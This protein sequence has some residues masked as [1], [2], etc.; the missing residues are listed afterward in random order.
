M[1]KKNNFFSRKPF[2]LLAA[3]AVLLAGST[4]G[5]TR[6]ALTYYS[7]NYSAE[8][9]VPSI[10]VSLLE[11]GSVVAKRDY[12]HK[13]DQWNTVQEP[14]FENTLNG[15]KLNRERNIKRYL[16]SATVVPL[17]TM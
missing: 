14:L 5:S 6:A 16:P 9:E 8:V 12:N 7:E 13:N 10:G 15:E 3:S 17:T 1:M 4:I 11:N 2:I